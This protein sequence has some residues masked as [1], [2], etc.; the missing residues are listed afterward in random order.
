MIS[1]L[2][3][4]NKVLAQKRRAAAAARRGSTLRAAAGIGERGAPRTSPP[5]GDGRSPSSSSPTTAPTSCRRRWPRCCAQ[6]ARRRR[7]RR[8]RQRVVATTAPAWLARTAR[9][10]LE[11]GREPRLRRRA[12][13]RARTRR[14][15]AAAAASSTPTRC[16]PPGCLDALRAA[17]GEH[18]RWGAWQALVTLPGGELVNT[19]GQRRALARL[20]LGRRATS[21]PVARGRRGAA[22]GRLRQRRGAVRAARRL[23]RRSAASTPRVLH[24]R[25]GPRPVAA[26][27]AGGLGQRRGARRARRARLRV[28]QGRLQV[29]LP[30]AQP[31]VDGARRLPG[32]RCW[33]LLAPG[34]AGVRGAR[35]WPAPRRGGWLRAKLRAQARSSAT[36]GAIADAPPRDAGDGTRR[37]PRDFAAALTAAMD[38]P[39]LAAHPRA[40]ACCCA[41]TGDSSRRCSSHAP[42][43]RPSLPRAGPDRRA[44]D[45]RP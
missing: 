6:L 16:R 34:A 1:R 18:P 25:R 28:H 42:R 32:A 15:A 23:G 5:S 39:F 17:A 38:S 3:D 9:D 8:R 44:R 27:A 22:R 12:A 30:R 19:A 37:A 14:R 4:Q 13:T 35:C 21:A 43:L 11:L 7:A 29:V 26:P 20:R 24:V 31:A 41:P 40:R 36:C 2:A 45:L 10:V 33:L